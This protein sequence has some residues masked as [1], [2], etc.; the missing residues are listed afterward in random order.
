LTEYKIAK[1]NLVRVNKRW[2]TWP[3]YCG[4]KQWWLIEKMAKEIMKLLLTGGGLNTLQSMPF[5]Q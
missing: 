5:K 4:V 1:K 3:P 2:G